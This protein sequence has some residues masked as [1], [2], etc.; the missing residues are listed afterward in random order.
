M[1]QVHPGD[2]IS[3]VSSVRSNTPP[4]PSN[5]SRRAGPLH[6]K[7]T[8]MYAAPLPLRQPA[9]P[10]GSTTSY[11]PNP[12]SARGPAAPV[13]PAPLPGLY[14]HGLHHPEAPPGFLATANMRQQAGYSTLPGQHNLPP[15][16]PQSQAGTGRPHVVSGHASQQGE[17]THAPPAS[18]I[19]AQAML[20]S[21]RTGQMQSGPV[22]SFHLPV[23][24]LSAQQGFSQDPI[25]APRMANVPASV[26]NSQSSTGRV[27]PIN[28][29]R[30]LVSYMRVC[31]AIS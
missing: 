31:A 10:G 7:P 2:S 23:N 12:R 6:S 8:D 30:E 5:Q 13:T 4:P 27:A 14:G 18:N 19:Y 26:A 21:S 9:P 29:N 16:S 28:H 3:Q 11:N 1:L 20:P 25:Q 24:P 15:M 22:A 17:P